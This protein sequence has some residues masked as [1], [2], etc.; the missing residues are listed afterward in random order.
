MA[1]EPEGSVIVA[2]SQTSGRGRYGRSWISPTG[3]GLYC[4]ILLRPPATFSQPGL[5]SCA[6]SLAV[7]DALKREC[8]IQAAVKWP[9]D[10]LIGRQKAAGV[11]VET[12]YQDQKPVFII[13]GVGIN[14]FPA[15][16]VL[17]VAPDA[18][19]VQN[20]CKKPINKDRILERLLTEFFSH[21]HFLSTTKPAARL[22]ARWLKHCHHMNKPV[23]VRNQAESLHG[24]FSGLDA[25]GA[26]LV[27]LDTGE[28][29]LVHSGDFSLREEECS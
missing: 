23:H 21:Y 22:R 24:I 2:D 14:L 15:P 18:A 11:L 16:A 8:G 7:V 4:S 28:T 3:K 17:N 27:E 25:S 1:G 26:A 29:V 12:H 9:N 6:A 19:A 20:F 10:V 5:L 13:V